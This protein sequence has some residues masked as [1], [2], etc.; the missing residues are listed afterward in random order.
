MALS[1]QLAQLARV[2]RGLW[3]A[4]LAQRGQLW[5]REGW[6][7]PASRGN[8]DAR[9]PESGHLALEEDSARQLDSS[10]TSLLLPHR[11]RLDPPAPH[12][13]WR[14]AKP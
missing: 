4:R 1:S 8:R 14:G 9:S 11:C 2:A 3:K 12:R 10:G 6:Q 7:I 13:Y 5:G